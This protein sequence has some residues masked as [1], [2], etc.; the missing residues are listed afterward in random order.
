MPRLLPIFMQV[1]SLE[2]RH[3]LKLT[4]CVWVNGFSVHFGAK[5]KAPDDRS[6]QMTLQLQCRREGLSG[7]LHSKLKIVL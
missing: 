6:H 3:L 2:L 5:T 4:S 7:T 1:P